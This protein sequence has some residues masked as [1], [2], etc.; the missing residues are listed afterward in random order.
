MPNDALELM[1]QIPLFRQL[2]EAE[3]TLLWAMGQETGVPAG[4]ALE[5]PP[6]EPPLLWII[7]DGR[8]D[9]TFAFPRIE[10]GH[11]TMFGPEIW[12][13]S[14]LVPPFTSPGRAV[15][16]TPCRV[17]KMGA[18]ELRT[19]AEQNP[20]LGMRL[21]EELATHF[22]RRFRGLLEHPL[23]ERVVSPAS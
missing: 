20:R 13:A 11:S 6:G 21:Y 12:G 17:L 7:L 9:I 3:L 18:Q 19:L 15:T 22:S 14:S 1:K 10:D 4:Y 5:V 16:G 23:S 2:G 8:A